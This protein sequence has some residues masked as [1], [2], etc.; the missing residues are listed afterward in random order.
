YIEDTGLSSCRFIGNYVSAA[1]KP[2]KYAGGALYGV[3][4]EWSNASNY[5]SYGEWNSR[6]VVS[7]DHF[8][9][10]AISGYTPKSGT[11]AANA[12]RYIE[13][14]FQDRFGKRRP[15]GSTW[16]AGAVQR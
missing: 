14:V 5:K 6:G 13:G 16:T 15:G 9:D 8:S 4:Q 3:W 7:N 2:L 12:G 10:V 1:A 11:T